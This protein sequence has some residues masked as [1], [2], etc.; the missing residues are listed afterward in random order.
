[1]FSAR[2]HDAQLAV[3]IDDVA[4]ANRAGDRLGHE[5]LHGSG[6]RDRSSP[7]RVGRLILSNL[8]AS[9]AVRTPRPSVSRLDA[10]LPVPHLRPMNDDPT[11]IPT[12]EA[13]SPSPWWMPHRH[14]DRRPFLARPQ[15]DQIRNPRAWFEAARLHRG[16]ARLPAGVAWQRD[17]PARVRDRAYRHRS[18][19]PADVSAHQPRVRDEEA[20][21]GRRERHLRVRARVSAIASG[22]PCIRPNSRCSNGIERRALRDAMAGLRR[23]RRHRARTTGHSHWSWRGRACDALAPHDHTTVDQAFADIAEVA[24]HE[25]YE[26][27]RRR[28]RRAGRPRSCPRASHLSGRHVVGH[29]QQGADRSYRTPTGQSPPRSFL[30]DYPHHE[31]ALARPVPANPD[32]PSASSCTSAVSRLANGFGELTDPV[33]QRRRLEAEMAE[34]AR[35]Y[36]E[37]YPIDEDFLAG[38][39]TYATSLGLRDGLRSPGHAGDRCHRHRP[40]VVDPATAGFVTTI[41]FTAATD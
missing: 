37:R 26:R 22:A 36:D 21:G 38:P 9:Y 27:D 18:L 13:A 25:T 40:G 1:M 28:S 12:R 32:L 5:D 33:E 17:T 23:P 29:F 31:A 2:H 3:E 11:K 24:L 10:A 7:D 34:K 15:P 6:A 41:W 14:Q 39:R 30:H 16:R 20:A 4:F 8:Q 19:P 35:I